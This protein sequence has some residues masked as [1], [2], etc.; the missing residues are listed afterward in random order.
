[1]K[2]LLKLLSTIFALLVFQLQV[3]GWDQVLIKMAEEFAKDPTNVSWQQ[4]A[5]MF[6]RN[7]E[8]NNMAGRGAIS[9]DAYQKSQAMF[10]EMND[11]ISKQAAQNAGLDISKQVSKTPGKFNPWTDTD[12]LVGKKDGRVTLQDIKNCRAEYNKLVNEFLEKYQVNASRNTDWAKRNETDFM[13]QA[14]QTRQFQT[15]NKW[16]NKMGGT[17]Y[18]SP[19]AANV[20]KLIRA[21]RPFLL[22]LD[23]AK[24]YNVEMNIQIEHKLHILDKTNSLIDRLKAN[25]YPPGSPRLELIEKLEASTQKLNHQIAKYLVRKTDINDIMVKR[26]GVGEEIKLD[27][28]V[29]EAAS[30]RDPVTAQQAEFVGRQARDLMGQADSNFGKTTGTISKF[31]QL[32]DS[33]KVVELR[34]KYYVYDQARGALGDSNLRRLV[35]SPDRAIRDNLGVS[36]G[37]PGSIQRLTLTRINTG[38]KV[39]GGILMAFQVYDVLKE[40]YRTGNYTQGALNLVIMYGFAKGAEYAIT[41]VFGSVLAANPVTATA[42]GVFM[43]SYGLTRE[44]FSRVTVGGK[45]LD[46]HVQDQMDKYYFKSGEYDQAA[47]NQIVKMYLDALGKGY[48]LANGMTQD[49]ALRKILE[50]YDKGGKI[51]EGIFEPRTGALNTTIENSTI[52]NT[53]SGSSEASGK[54]KINTGIS[55]VNAKIENSTIVNEGNVDAVAK[56]NSRINTGVSVNQSTVENSNVYVKTDGEATAINNS[57]V[58]AGFAANNANIQNSN[59]SSNVQGTFAAKDNSTLNAGIQANNSK[60]S[61]ADMSNKVQGANVTV[62]NRSTVNMGTKLDKDANEQEPDLQFNFGK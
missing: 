51:F 38:L 6:S 16:I 57:T 29:Y 59:I 58:N 3:I 4:K 7:S 41:S 15:I 45:T 13:P 46:G 49:E 33:L 24:T 47:K 1:M 10:Q 60:I 21:R 40:S 12:N 36:R 19:E 62:K 22:T 5:Y 14:N 23:N 35:T 34:A 37:G 25:N 53:V 9:N 30:Q 28:Q 55:A 31:N 48:K 54:S 50:N 17:A 27:K 56:E 8:I 2:R 26:F 32:N 18:E 43:V 39:G 42:I 20:E 11:N 61:N 44:V 52:S